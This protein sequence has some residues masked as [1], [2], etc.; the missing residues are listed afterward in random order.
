MYKFRYDIHS[1]LSVRSALVV[2]FL[3]VVYPVVARVFSS[4]ISLILLS[5]VLVLFIAFSCFS[6]NIFIGV[7]LDKQAAH[8]NTLAHAARPLAFSTPAAWQAVLTRSHWSHKTPQSLS[9]LCPSL[10]VVSS[11]L[12]DIMIFVV[13]DFVLTWYKDISSSPS[14]PTAVS[15]ILHDSL[16]LFLEKT[17]TLDV[18]ALLVKRVLP[19]ITAHIE[20]FRQSE[21]AL[22]GAALERRLTQSDELDMLLASRYAGKG[23]KLHPAVENLSSTFTKQNEEIHLRAIAERVLSHILPER[24]AQSRAQRIIIRE[25]LTCALLYPIM[26]MVTDPD[27]WNQTIEQ[28]VCQRVKCRF[29]H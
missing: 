26:D 27:F 20:Q 21:V 5:P 17:A 9:P 4:P 11:T 7:A 6:A 1:L 15:S 16:A 8:R 25:I 19:K 23:G 14:F 10:P 13:R 24:E 22:R 2:A 28:V 12:N 3:A 18:S 29:I